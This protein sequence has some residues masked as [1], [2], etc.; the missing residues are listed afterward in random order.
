[1]RYTLPSGKLFFRLINI[2]KQLEL[3]NDAFVLA[4]IKHNGSTVAPLGK[5]ES[6]LC[7]PDLL[8]E[9]RGIGT[10]FGNRFDVFT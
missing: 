4:D 7:A 6:A 5:D 8:D 9:G 1:M 10:E 2:A 3:F